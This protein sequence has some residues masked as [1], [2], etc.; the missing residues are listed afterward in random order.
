[1]KTKRTFKELYSF[2]G[3]RAKARFKSG[4][5]G[6]PMA[7]VVELERRQKKVYVPD[8][9]R[10]RQAFMTGASIG[11]GMRTVAVCACTLSLITGAL[12]VRSVMP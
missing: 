4:I 8:A 3:F 9:G 7:R 10:Q 12:I 2:P 5:L 11:Y 6:D 1:M